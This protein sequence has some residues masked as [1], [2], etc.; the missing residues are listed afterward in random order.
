MDFMVL[1]WYLFG[2]V[3]FVDFMVLVNS[4]FTRDIDKRISL[5]RYVFTFRDCAIN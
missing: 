1:V 2:T 3:G 4:D 5:T